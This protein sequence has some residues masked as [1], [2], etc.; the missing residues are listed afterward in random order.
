VASPRYHTRRRSLDSPSTDVSNMSVT[1]RDVAK[2]AAVSVTTASRAI[3][4][5]GPVSAAVAARV[6]A[7]A[8]ELHY[9]PDRSAR[10]LKSGRTM[11][12]GLVFPRTAEGYVG[13]LIRGAARDA[14]DRGYHL[15]LPPP[16]DGIDD[17]NNTILGMHGCV[18]GILLLAPDLTTRD[19]LDHVNLKVPAILVTCDRSPAQVRTLRLD[20]F[21]AARTMTAHLLAG[22]ARH[23]AM[24]TGSEASVVAYERLRGFRAAVADDPEC[25]ARESEGDSSMEGGY[26]ATIRL[27]RSGDPPG[28]IFCVD[29]ATALGAIVALG[30]CGVAVP[31][32]LTVGACEDDITTASL[33]PALTA[34]SFDMEVLGSR[35]VEIL[36]EAFSGASSVDHEI[37]RARMVDYA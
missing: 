16:Y 3:N 34:M 11:N 21:G 10:S 15:M 30:S 31:A 29:A 5:I 18:D 1:L 13:R 2:R 25:S 14:R 36:C 32:Q 28:A 26:R 35:A 19:I 6:R 7:A 20:N 24:I 33:R 23:I 4:G 9:A 37:V 12:V 27:M 17:L 22:G 8:V